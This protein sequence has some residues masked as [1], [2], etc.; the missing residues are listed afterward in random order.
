MEL[1][2]KLNLTPGAITHITNKLYEKKLISR[3][4]DPNSRRSI[5]YAITQDGLDVLKEARETGQKIQ[6]EIL[7]VLTVEEQKQMLALY[8]KINKSFANK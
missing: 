5:C 8:K 4:P 3:T 6:M 7:Q 2:K 1:A